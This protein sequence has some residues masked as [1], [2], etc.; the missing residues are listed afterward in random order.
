MK[1]KLVLSTQV[2][3]G[4]MK[5][6]YLA[7]WLNDCHS[8]TD[9]K[10]EIQESSEYSDK[11]NQILHLPVLLMNTDQ[12]CKTDNLN[13]RNTEVQYIVTSSNV[14]TKTDIQNSR[15]EAKPMFAKFIDDAYEHGK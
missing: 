5:K 4:S 1:K 15:C 8:D 7:P 3:Q 14:Q 10:Y 13:I 9:I 11:T 6:R 12:N 2:T